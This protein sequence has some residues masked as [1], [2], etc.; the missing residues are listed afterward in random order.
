MQVRPV[1]TV[2]FLSVMISA[3]TQLSAQQTPDPSQFMKI[4]AESSSL[5]EHD[6]KPWHLRAKYQQLKP[7]GSLLHEGSIEIWWASDTE[8]KTSYT[9]AEYSRLEYRSG[10]QTY[11]TGQENPPPSLENLVNNLLLHPLPEASR[12][13]RSPF[14]EKDL[15]LSGTAFQCYYQAADVFTEVVRDSAGQTTTLSPSNQVFCF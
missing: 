9:G 13:T 2:L 12:I 6:M 4:A 11:F 14:M 1:P 5:I 15:T 8:L 7:D 3:L 10:T